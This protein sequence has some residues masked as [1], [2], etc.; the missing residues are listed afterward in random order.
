MA[1]LPHSTHCAA[2]LLRARACPSLARSFLLACS[3]FVPCSCLLLTQYRLGPLKVLSLALALSLALQF[4]RLLLFS[5][6]PCSC[7]F[8]PFCRHLRWD[9]VS[10]RRLI[11]PLLLYVFLA[12]PWL[13][14][15]RVSCSGTLSHP[16]CAF[17]A[18]GPPRC[19]RVSE[20]PCTTSSYL[21]RTTS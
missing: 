5:V 20:S 17:A 6:S 13:M 10:R 1:V 4:R 14:C 19:L 12:V 18:S 8:P 3:A 2:P 16:R 7:C 9:S 21:L 15:L 11:V